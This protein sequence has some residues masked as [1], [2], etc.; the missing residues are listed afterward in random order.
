MAIPKIL[1]CLFEETLKVSDGDVAARGR[2]RKERSHCRFSRILKA[3]L[4]ETSLVKKIRKRKVRHNL[5]S[6][7]STKSNEIETSVNAKKNMHVESSEADELPQINSLY[8]SSRA[9][10]LTSNLRSLSERKCSL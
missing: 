9:S 3:V 10:S 1:A 8:C 2:P 6:D 4:F 7:L 5:Q